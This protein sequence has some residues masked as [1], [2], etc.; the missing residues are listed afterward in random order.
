MWFQ[1]VG[2][3]SCR[4]E[5]S[6]RRHIFSFRLSCREPTWRR[7]CCRSTINACFQFVLEAISLDQSWLPFRV[8][9]TPLTLTL[10]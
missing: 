9:L 2:L 4:Q 6:G 8:K 7:V 1:N 3:C 5:T 10:S